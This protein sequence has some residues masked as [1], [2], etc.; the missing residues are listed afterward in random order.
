VP[1]KGSPIISGNM[2]FVCDYDG[3]LWAFVGHDDTATGRPAT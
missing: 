1:V 2:L 3:N